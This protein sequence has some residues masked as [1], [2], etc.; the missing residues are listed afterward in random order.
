M[1]EEVIKI[2]KKS[3]I[4]LN[5][6]NIEPIIQNPKDN[7]QA[8]LASNIAFLLSNDLKQ[9]PYDI[10]INIKNDLSSSDLFENVEVA[11]PGFINFKIKSKIIVGQLKNII[12][13]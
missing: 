11:K 9:S 4:N 10:A 3:L 7:I 8:D 2:L 12:L 13:Q 1:K 5:Y 6:P